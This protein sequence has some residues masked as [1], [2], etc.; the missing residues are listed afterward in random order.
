[1]D[2][3][4]KVVVGPNTDPGVTRELSQ[5]AWNAICAKWGVP[6]DSS[7]IAGTGVPFVTGVKPDHI[8]EG[9]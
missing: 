1:M 9:K 6:A 8:R 3:E 2:A 4:R 5:E 7:F